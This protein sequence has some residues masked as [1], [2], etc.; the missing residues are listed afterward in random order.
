LE[1]GGSTTIEVEGQ[2]GLGRISLAAMLIPTND[3]FLAAQNVRLPRG[4]EAI[5]IVVPAYDAGSEPND[6]DCKNIPGPV[7][8]G[9]GRRRRTAKVTCTSMQVSTESPTSPPRPAI[10]A[11]PLP[12]S[13]S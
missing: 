11:I 7:C 3:A 10:G 2:P 1:P 4:H 8:G 9:E 13:R 5:T 6:E 12:V